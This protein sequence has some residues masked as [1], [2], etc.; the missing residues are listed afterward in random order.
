MV[1]QASLPWQVR[2]CLFTESDQ[3]AI[4]INHGTQRCLVLS[5]A[6]ATQVMW[7]SHLKVVA[8]ILVGFFFSG[9]QKALHL[10]SNPLIQK[11]SILEK[12]G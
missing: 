10:N 9:Y 1:Y 7:R 8:L 6:N 4:D 2:S 3:L 5:K 12:G 11:K